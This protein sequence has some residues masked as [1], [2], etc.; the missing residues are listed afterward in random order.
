MLFDYVIANM[1]SNNNFQRIVTELF[2]RG[3]KLN[4][5]LVF[6]TQS[7]FAITKNIK[8]SSTHYFLMKILNERELQKITINHSTDIE[9][10]DF[11]NLY[12]KCTAEMYFFLVNNT[13]PASDNPLDFRCSVLEI[14]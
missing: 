7:Y 3:R 9:F 4:I 8:L 1:L 2:I 5:F 10:K 11:M 12:K 14:I 13:T 6:I